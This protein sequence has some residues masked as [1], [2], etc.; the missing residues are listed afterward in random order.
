M[1]IKKVLVLDDENYRHNYY[2]KL[3]SNCEYFEARNAKTAIELLENEADIDL[4]HL[5]FD[6][7]K[8]PHAPNEYLTGLA[9]VE[10]IIDKLDRNKI[11]KQI[12][13]HSWNNKGHAQMMKILSLHKLKP[14]SEY[15]PEE[16][17]PFFDETNEVK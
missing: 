17:I 8:T 2:K 11:P 5:D 12:K 14:I 16:A 6:L 13:V 3:Y 7:F 4:L 10:Y 1:H 9:V 15:F